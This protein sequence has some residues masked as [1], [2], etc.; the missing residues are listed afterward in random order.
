MISRIPFLICALL[1]AFSAVEAGVW[2]NLKS[3]FVAEEA[4][5][6]PTI[7]VLLAHD[8]PF[9]N[10][11]VKGSYNLYDPHKNRR[12]ATRF[13]GR[14]NRV[15]PMPLG[16]KWGEEFPGYY[17]FEIIPDSP[18]IVTNINGN[19]YRGKIY[20]YD[21]GGSIS[22]VNEIELEDYLTSV[23]PRRIGR[24]VSEEGVAAAAIAE[25]TDAFYRSMNAE[26]PYWH[27]RARD[28]GYYGLPNEAIDPM[29][30]KALNSTRH[31]VLS[32]TGLY[33]GVV[34]PFP[35]A[36]VTGLNDHV[37]QPVNKI[38]LD[39]IEVLSRQG[40]NAAK[41]LSK[42]FPEAT[43]AM[44]ISKEKKEGQVAEVRVSDYSDHSA[45]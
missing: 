30:A 17:Q 34:T 6:T 11:E 42:T 41:I 29:I 7:K 28:V 27:V 10:V 26:N 20:I 19:E 43:I 18:D 33:E 36:L 23:L 8:I 44:T 13:T 32:K 21:V 9:A 15:E 22:I 35:V 2:D 38:T 12:I 14:D 39:D 45:R 24:R 3:V 16:L 25:R 37:E 5:E 4:V 40:I 1:S 31:I